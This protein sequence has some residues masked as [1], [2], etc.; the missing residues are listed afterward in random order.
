MLEIIYQHACLITLQLWIV[1]LYPLHQ[2]ARLMPE[3]LHMVQLQPIAVSQVT[4]FL[5]VQHAPVR[6]MGH[7]Q[8]VSQPVVSQGLWI[9]MRNCG[10]NSQYLISPVG[11]VNKQLQ[12]YSLLYVYWHMTSKN[13]RNLMYAL[14]HSLLYYTATYIAKCVVYAVHYSVCMRLVGVTGLD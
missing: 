14:T 6:P 7:G 5:E 11:G 1:E 10:L 12:Q 2:T 3:L 4:L 9:C 13:F 8:A